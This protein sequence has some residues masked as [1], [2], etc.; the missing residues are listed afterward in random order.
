MHVTAAVHA[1]SHMPTVLITLNRELI[2][3]R[4][5]LIY[6][7]RKDRKALPQWAGLVFLTMS[8]QRLAPF[9]MKLTHYLKSSELIISPQVRD[10]QIDH[11]LGKKAAG[12]WQQATVREH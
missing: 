2:V 1:H 11:T 3:I 12:N 7:Y 8:A 5:C 9:S 6:T 10:P 4:H